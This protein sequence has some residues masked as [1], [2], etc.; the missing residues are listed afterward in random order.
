MVWFIE[1]CRWKKLRA[2]L[3]LLLGMFSRS[4]RLV[5]PCSG[6]IRVHRG[7]TAKDALPRMHRLR[8]GHHLPR[9][10]LHALHYML[11][12]KSALQPGPPPPAQPESGPPP[13]TAYLSRLSR[14]LARF[15]FAGNKTADIMP[16][17]YRSMIILFRYFGGCRASA[18]KIAND[19]IRRR[20]T[21]F[22]APFLFKCIFDECCC[23]SLYLARGFS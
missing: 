6:R 15:L 16:H 14:S 4:P 17:Y 22:A 2:G 19:E 20:W 7:C 11:R 3:L 13:L 23:P 9:T 12:G 1:G 10:V 21:I 8:V 18:C 5:V